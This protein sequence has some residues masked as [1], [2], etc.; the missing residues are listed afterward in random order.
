MQHK[1][2]ILKIDKYI[3]QH[4]KCSVRQ[5]LV[6]LNEK[7]VLLNKKTAKYNAIVNKGDVVEINKV[8][9]IEKEF[10][11]TYIA[12]HKPKGIVCTS[13]KIED[14][15]IDAIKHP[16][17]I[18]PIGRLDKDSEGL[19]LLT[20]VTAIIDKVANPKFE[21]EKEYEVT[22][23]LPLTD[24]FIADIK[25]G[26]DIGGGVTTSP[27]EVFVVPHTKR[28]FRI[29]LKQGLNRQIRKMCN[30]YKYQVIKLQRI[31]VM[32]LELGDLKVGEWRDL[33][34]DEIKKLQ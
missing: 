24:K 7:R 20:N 1:N 26:I 14:N 22:L 32:N 16:E 11:P 23:N 10:T 9:V 34:S 31:R 27:C 28:V 30:K 19:I 17:N 2:Y 3:S 29:I 13:E 8:R 33:T 15:I 4:T 21:H 5:A 6:L 12:Y 25:K 18:Y